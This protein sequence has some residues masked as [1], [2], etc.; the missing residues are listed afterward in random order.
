[1]LTLH[2][3]E[4]LHPWTGDWTGMQERR[5]IRV[6][7]TYSKT[8]YF[9]D[10]GTQRGATYDRLMDFERY[11]NLKLAKEKKL[12][13]RHLKMRV[14]FIPVT[15]AEL[16]KALQEGKGDIAAANLTI[17]EAR[18]KQVDFTLPLYKG[19][20][21]LLLSGAHSP[22]VT[23]LE[24]LA[25][26]TVFVRESSSYYDSLKALNERFIRQGLAPV[27]LQ[28]A[29]DALEDE[30]LIEMLNA[31][32]IPLIVVDSHKAHFWQQIFPAVKVHDDIALRQNGEIAWAIRKESPEL[33]AL[34]NEFI[35]LH[36]PSSAVSNI[37]ANRYFKSTKYVK[38]AN[39]T[40]SRET[41]LSMVDLFKQ[42]GEKYDVDWLL[43]AAQGY[44][45]SQLNQKARSHVGAIGVMQ[46]MPKTGK[47]LKV[48]DIRQLEPNIHA[49]IKY[50]RWMIDHYYQ[51]EPMTRLDKA[52][53]SFAS[54]NA[55][56]AR[57]ARLRK[58]T[59][60]RGFNPNVWF[61]HVELIAAE[62]IGS[63]TVSYVSNIYKYYIAYKL[64]MAGL[65]EK[66]QITQGFKYA[67]PNPQ[68]QR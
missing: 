59:A 60:E 29:P 51:D 41:F 25:G 66:Q 56:P 15:R 61:G 43:M 23:K 58:L 5:V 42:Y 14:I 17:T 50:M 4:L 10:K 37:V 48:G 3:E 45:E 27:I 38:D 33:R 19:V 1:M 40:K 57:I 36:G 7:T 21:E 30:D 2:E 63:E 8:F 55:G 39:S 46:I 9:V 6:L 32:L 34:L 35:T 16:F 68:Q 28:A 65:A 18:S 62:K 53:F 47:D 24:D 31:G 49:G 54:Y 20:R 44:Q 13:Q 26:K 11:L 22:Q 64:V 52:L 12:A 67:P